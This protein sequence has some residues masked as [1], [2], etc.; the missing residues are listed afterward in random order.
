VR[1]NTAL[2]F[3]VVPEALARVSGSLHKQ[4]AVPGDPTARPT[5]FASHITAGSTLPFRVSNVYILMLRHFDS[6]A[7][8]SHVDGGACQ[9][10]IEM[11]SAM[12]RRCAGL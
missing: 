3:G 5:G 11:G 10:T 1:G 4:L 7:E 8:N 12:V 6:D 2:E 9:R